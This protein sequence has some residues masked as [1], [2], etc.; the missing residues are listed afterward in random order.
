[1]RSRADHITK[2][3]ISLTILLMYAVALIAGQARANVTD[4]DTAG[5]EAAHRA[6][7]NV[8]LEAEYLRKLESLSHL[9]DTSLALPVDV[10]FLLRDLPGRGDSH[11]ESGSDD[12]SL[13]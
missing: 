11:G 7:L 13:Q 9:F 10:E 12:A 8:V 5:D 3:L 4:A 1:M 6:A 2:G